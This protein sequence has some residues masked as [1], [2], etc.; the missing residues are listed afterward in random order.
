MKYFGAEGREAA[1]YD[2]GDEAAMH[3][4][5]LKTAYSLGAFLNFGQS[6]ILITG[7]LIAVSW[8]LAAHRG[9][10]RARMTVGDFVMVNAYM[11]QITV[12][13]N[14]LGTVYREIRQSAC[15]HGGNVRSA[16]PARRNVQ[17]KAWSASEL[18]GD[19]AGKSRLE[20]RAFRL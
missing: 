11:I 13:L 4:A 18:A 1:R 15:G 17:D 6:L 8:S 7:G 12:P 3:D 2:S 5:A 10:R 16:G 19:R 14:F 9:C 20:D